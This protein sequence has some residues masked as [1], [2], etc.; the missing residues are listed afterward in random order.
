MRGME[1]FFSGPRM[2]LFRAPGTIHVPPEEIKR[3]ER[4]FCDGQWTQLLSATP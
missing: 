3:R 4:L 1:A 2:L